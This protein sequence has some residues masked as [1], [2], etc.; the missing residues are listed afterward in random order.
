MA[1]EIT[2]SDAMMTGHAK[3]DDQ[4][5]RMVSMI[6]RL[7]HNSCDDEYHVILHELA[8]Y[9]RVHF[10]QEEVMFNCTSYPDKHE[11]IKSHT[12]YW[13]FMADLA[14]DSMGFVTPEQRDRLQSFL[15]TWWTNHI[16]HDD[17]AYKPY[18]GEL[19]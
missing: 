13:E 11:H 17:M 2:W 16:M 8:C 9:A 7:Q 14:Y 12:R 5:K 18:L 1:S 10:E 3:I 4:H 6:N 19:S 15:T